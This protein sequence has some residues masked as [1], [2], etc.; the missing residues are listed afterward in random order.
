M[1]LKS[2]LLFAAGPGKLIY[3]CSKSAN[4]VTVLEDPGP[5]EPVPAGD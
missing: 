1:I 2:R 5:R 3:V 4:H